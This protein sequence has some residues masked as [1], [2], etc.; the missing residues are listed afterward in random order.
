PSQAPFNKVPTTTQVGIHVQ[1][2]Q[3][4]R[5]IN[6]DGSFVGVN[7]SS[8]QDNT[9]GSRTY[10]LFAEKEG[11]YLLYTTGD[12]STTGQQ[13][14]QGLFG[15]V[16]VQPSTAEWYRS[17]VTQQDMDL[18]I[19]HT[20]GTNGFTALHQPIINY[21]AKYPAGHPR[22][23]TYILRMLDDQ[24]DIIHSDL[25]A[26]ITG[27]RHGRFSGTTGPDREEPP[28]S[29]LNDPA[30]RTPVDPLFCKNS[31]SPDRKQP[32][33]EVT[34]MYHE[35]VGQA[36]QAFP[37]FTQMNAT[38]QAGIDGFAINYG[39]GGIGAEIYANRIGVGPMGNCV[40]CK[41]E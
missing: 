10:V 12:L 7:D 31:P 35:V 24:N 2:M 4:V 9:G 27:P 36:V 8:L 5:T 3:V 29:L 34:I 26:I 22:A 13:L 30:N 20:K 14:G 17:Q 18:A 16:N 40:D 19:D 23:G 39:T 38:T 6:D 21:D 15:S 37:I 28:C 25:T 33:R 32:Y 41:F 1:G 11:T